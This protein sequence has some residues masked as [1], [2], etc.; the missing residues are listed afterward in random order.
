MIPHLP[1][2][3]GGPLVLRVPHD[4]H[5][6]GRTQGEVEGVHHVNVAVGVPPEQG[7]RGSHH[8]GSDLLVPRLPGEPP[9]SDKVHDGH[10]VTRG[11]GPVVEFLPPEG[12]VPVGIRGEEEA[13]DD[14]GIG[15][16]P[17]QEPVDHGVR[18][19]PGLRKVPGIEGGPVELQQSPDKERMIV[20]VPGDSRL[21]VSVPVEKLTVRCPETGHDEPFRGPGRLQKGFPAHGRVRPCQGCHHEAVPVREDLVVQMRSD[22]FSP[23]PEH[24]APDVL[25]GSVQLPP[26]VGIP[27]ESVPDTPG[28]MRDVIPVAAWSLG[29]FS[30]AGLSLAVLSMVVWSL[31]MLLLAVRSV[32]VVEVT[33]LPQGEKANCHIRIPGAKPLP[34]LVHGPEVEP[35]L[36]PLAV[37]IL[38]RIE[39]PPGGG[40]V[41]C[42]ILRHLPDG[43]PVVLIPGGTVGLGVGHHEQ[44]LI[45]EHLLEVGHQPFP[46][47]GIPVEPV[48][49]LVVHAAVPH[50]VKGQ[51]RHVP[52]PRLPG[53]LPVPEEEQQMVRCGEL[54]FPAESPLTGI[55]GCFQSPVGPVQVPHPRGRG[56]GGGITAPFG[57]G[58]RTDR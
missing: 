56:A 42:H 13:A 3:G 44:G 15:R 34:E 25:Q 20:E 55:E 6:P 40:Q 53:P 31:A 47:R 41:P 11:D 10:R 18:E 43:A 17:V 7:C 45:V 36:L 19:L 8:P 30:L 33:R 32:R 35:P 16:V 52:G 2:Q 27:L 54:R 14:A 4:H 12:K 5:L 22:P 51:L 39:P 46:I 50:P 1:Q 48:P 37:G 57:A 26:C 49:D 58:G 21:P 9:Q 24:R 38:G 29:G 28:D 23:E